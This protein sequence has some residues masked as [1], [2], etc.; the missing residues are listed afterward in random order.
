[1]SE[2]DQKQTRAEWLAEMSRAK[3]ARYVGIAAIITALGGGTVITKALDSFGKSRRV[4][5]SL[6][7][8]SKEKW[9][10]LE[11]RLGVVERL[12]GVPGVGLGAPPT[13]ISGGGVG[14]STNT[15]YGL[16]GDEIFEEADEPVAE[17]ATMPDAPERV[18]V[19]VPKVP[20]S[21]E[22]LEQLVQDGGKY[23]TK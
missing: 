5:E 8:I 2:E 20:Q 19:H 6:F 11:Y 21:F 18:E 9:V 23:E 12:C 13:P 17:E 22:E 14:M 16:V 3:T 1:M 10:L 7:N 4:Q 15:H